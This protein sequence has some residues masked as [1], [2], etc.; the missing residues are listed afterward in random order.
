MKSVDYLSL[1]W[2]GIIENMDRIYHRKAREQFGDSDVSELLESTSAT[3]IIFVKSDEEVSFDYKVGKP[4]KYDIF[5]LETRKEL[6]QELR[7]LLINKYEVPE[8]I[9]MRFHYQGI[10]SPRHQLISG[11]CNP[12]ASCQKFPG[13]LIYV[14]SQCC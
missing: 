8:E 14:G 3:N 13:R 11:S 7:S 4:T 10:P 9:A 6:T 1:D 2:N 5:F 12:L